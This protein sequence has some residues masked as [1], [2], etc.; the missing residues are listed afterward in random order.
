MLELEQEFS[1]S[2]HV[3]DFNQEE[4]KRL[5]ELDHRKYR[6]ERNLEEEGERECVL[7]G[8]EEDEIESPGH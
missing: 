2:I 7:E 6:R 8:G 3:S 1:T 5:R 4:P